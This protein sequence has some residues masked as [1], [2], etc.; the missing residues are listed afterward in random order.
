MTNIN[1]EEDSAA[2]AQ[3]NGQPN[4]G[5]TNDSDVEVNT[6]RIAP[7][8][9]IRDQGN[10]AQADPKAPKENGVPLSE[11]LQGVYDMLIAVTRR[12]Q[13]LIFSIRKPKPEPE[14]GE[15]LQPFVNFANFIFLVERGLLTRS[16]LKPNEQLM[17]IG[18]FSA[19]MAKIWSTLN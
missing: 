7:E 2:K 11:Q 6:E 14:R 5:K 12:L 13:E 17:L 16:D 9:K 15:E 19:E 3:T 18:A 10:V 4:I 1:Q 8:Q